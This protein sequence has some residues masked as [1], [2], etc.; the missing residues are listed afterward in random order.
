MTDIA[1]HCDTWGTNV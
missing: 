1:A